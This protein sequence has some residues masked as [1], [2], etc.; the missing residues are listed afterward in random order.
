MLSLCTGKFFPELGRPQATFPPPAPGTPPLQ[1]SQLT[2]ELNPSPKL[3]LPTPHTDC[4]HLSAPVTKGSP[5]LRASEVDTEVPQGKANEVRL[6]TVTYSGP[7][8]VAADPCSGPQRP[9]AQSLLAQ[10]PCGYQK[11]AGHSSTKCGTL[12]TNLAGPW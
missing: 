5:V 9:I 1:N 3:G 10:Y 12:R 7:H 4:P 11:S 2:W 6:G 8:S